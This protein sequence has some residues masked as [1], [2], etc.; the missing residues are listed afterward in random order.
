M[1]NMMY[2]DLIIASKVAP[3]RKEYSSREVALDYRQKTLVK[4]YRY[5]NELPMPMRFICTW[6]VLIH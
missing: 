3:L 2:T 1:C 6:Y 4:V 5:I